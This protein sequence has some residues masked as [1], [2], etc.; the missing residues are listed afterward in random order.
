MLSIY[1]CATKKD[2]KTKVGQE[3]PFIETSF[4]GLEYTGKDGKYCVVGPS[5]SV[6]KWYATV[7]VKDGKISKVS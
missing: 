6:R 3:P 7:E 4:F 1:G 2:L 5:P